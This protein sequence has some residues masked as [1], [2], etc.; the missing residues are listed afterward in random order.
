MIITTAIISLYMMLVYV[1]GGDEGGLV[2][3]VVL[4]GLTAFGIIFQ[5]A[6]GRSK[7]KNFADSLV[8]DDADEIKEFVESLVDK[9]TNR[10]SESEEK[11]HSVLR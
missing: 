10:S 11:S 8:D 9:V 6:R 3:K 2:W 4:V 7:G 1:V 5:L